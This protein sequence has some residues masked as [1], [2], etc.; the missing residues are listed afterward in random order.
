YITDKEQTGMR[1]DKLLPELNSDWSRNQIQDWIKAGLVVA[2]DKVVKSNYKVK[3][4]DH[5]VVT[6]KEVVE[7]DILP[8][9]LNLDIYYED[10][11]VA[12]VYKP[13]GMVVH[14][15]PGHYTN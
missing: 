5:I 6:E 2:N 1:V 9:N 12:V 3:L 10:D 13:K 11:D 7:A 15:S 8:E 14:P 4:N